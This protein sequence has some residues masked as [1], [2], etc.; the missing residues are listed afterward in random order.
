[1]TCDYCKNP[2]TVRLRHPDGEGRETC[3]KHAVP[4]LRNGWVIVLRR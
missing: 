4:Y 2:W 1:M 3:D